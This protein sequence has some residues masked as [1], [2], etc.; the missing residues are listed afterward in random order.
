MGQPVAGNPT[1][2]MMERAFAA[3]NLDWRYLTLEVPPENLAEAIAGLRAM[4]FQGGNFTIPHKVAVIEHLDGLS[5]AAELMGAVNCIN[6][7]PDG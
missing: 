5:E 3:A 7:Q 2:F 4:G 6:R 1:Q